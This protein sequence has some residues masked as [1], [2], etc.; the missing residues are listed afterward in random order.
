MLIEPTQFMSHT[1]YDSNQ[2]HVQGTWQWGI[3]LLYML[4][5]GYLD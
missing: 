3:N 4:K 1:H 2:K 5:E